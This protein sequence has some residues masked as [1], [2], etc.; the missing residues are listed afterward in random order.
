MIHVTMINMCFYGAGSIS[1]SLG[2]G[3]CVPSRDELESYIWDY[4]SLVLL[5]LVKVLLSS[6]FYI[7]GWQHLPA[8]LSDLIYMNHK[9]VAEEHAACKYN[10][11]LE[12][13]FY[14]AIKHMHTQNGYLESR[15]FIANFLSSQFKFAAF[16]ISSI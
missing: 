11:D 16:L 14:N 5:L 13:I 3:D 7:S 9:F 15:N 12:V 1:S 6:L 2:L 8:V 10:G 4:I